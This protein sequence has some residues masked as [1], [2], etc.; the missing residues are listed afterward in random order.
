MAH[1]LL[2]L[3]YDNALSSLFFLLLLIQ[4]ANSATLRFDTINFD[5]NGSKYTENS[6]FSTNLKTLFSDLKTK[7]S[8]SISINQTSGEA[9]ATAFGLYFCTG[10]LSPED[11]QD[12]IETS[13]QEIAYSC[14]NDKQAIIRNDYCELRYSDTNFFGVPDTNGFSMSNP[15]ENTTSSRPVEVVSQ[16]VQE[17]P[18]VQPLMFKTQALINESLYA[19]AQC[20]SDLTSK[21]CSHCLTTILA[22]IKACCVGSKGWR[23]L[24]PSC[25]IRYEATP[26]LQNLNGTSTEIIKSYCPGN[27][28]PSVNVN[29]TSTIMNLLSILTEKAPAMEGF[30]NT[31]IEDGI[32]KL[33]GLALCRGD[34]QNK[35]DDCKSC[36]KNASASI[37]GDCPNKT[38]AIEWYEKC[39]VRYSSQLF[40]GVVDNGIEPFCG[41]QKISVDADNATT[42]LALRLINE[43]PN[44]QMFVRAG[45]VVINTSLTS[46]VLVQ[47]TRDLSKEGCRQ[48]LQTGMNSISSACKLTNGW[49]Y[50]S[51]SC[52]LRYEVNPFFNTSLISTQSPPASLQPNTPS[53]TND[54]SGNKSNSVSIAVIVA[55]VLGVILLG[56]SIFYMWWRLRRINERKRKLLDEYR[57]LTSNE[58]PFMDLATIQAA[59]GNFA[60]ENKLGEGGFGPV[61]KGVLNNGA[62]IAVKRL[63]TKSKQGATEF[64]TEVKLIAKLQHR[65]LV[66]MLGW[67]VEREEKLLIYEYL[68]NKSLDALLF[69][70]E[71]RAHLDWNTRLQIIGGIA[72]GLLYLHEDSLLKVIHRDLKASNVLLDNK[73]TPKI[74]DF[75][76]A[77]IFGGDENEA[78][79]NRVVGTYGYMAPEYAMAGLFSAKSD[80]FSFGVLMLEVLTG[81]RNGRAHFEEYG[82]TLIRNMWHKWIED[83]AL[84]LMDPLLGSSYSIN[85]AMKLI[86]VALLCVQENTEERPTMSLVVHMFRSSDHTVFPN[87]SQPPTF[88]M[89]RKNQ[90]DVSSPSLNSHPT[91]VHSINDVTNSE[92]LPR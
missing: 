81:E 61:Y 92:L 29:A 47:C 49:R 73:M 22:K 58:L 30:Y 28:F 85:D 66:R 11:C 76:M 60:D 42:K 5:C 46:Y 57:P 19:L 87:P 13:I 89:Q 86:K 37:V 41:V 6:T 32:N 80:V 3:H 74:S 54:G 12:C 84:E 38:Q 2:L 40:F 51:G 15:N 39:F 31:S 69:D 79:T 55:P 27:N 83:K 14:P 56:S 8:S 1:L 88:I 75:G 78:N 52:T 77:K 24:A 48:C 71:K 36:L 65:N 4:H 50:L 16:L 26:F 82:E 43:A 45:E 90:S 70:P 18:L 68:P 21:G 34:I 17:A 23:Y 91:S 25:W 7:S 72:R 64:E 10:D 44:D 33:Y 20:S 53:E 63:S 62:E 67:C 9:P 35:V 59:T